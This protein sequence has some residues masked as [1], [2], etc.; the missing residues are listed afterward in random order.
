MSSRPSVSLSWK[1]ESR[2]LTRSPT[3]RLGRASGWMPWKDKC[4]GLLVHWSPSWGV[5]A[6][7]TG[8]DSCRTR[9]GSGIDAHLPSWQAPLD[10]PPPPLPSTLTSRWKRMM[11][12]RAS[13]QWRRLGR[14]RC[15]RGGRY[16]KMDELGA[17]C[18]GCKARKY[19]CDH[20]NKTHAKTMT[21]RRLVSD[22][23]SEEEE[24]MK[25]RSHLP[26]QTCLVV[27]VAR[28]QPT[29]PA[30]PFAMDRP[31]APDLAALRRSKSAYH[32]SLFCRLGGVFFF[33]MHTIVGVTPIKESPLFHKSLTM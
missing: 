19:G 23:G 2:P 30:S 17:A 9:G 31:P 24:E 27:G 16:C 6:L 21:V 26:L 1:Q 20:T 25:V 11:P 5:S 15:E 33:F 4:T 18:A 10:P 14:T 7:T 29:H 13:N 8:S 22:S 28:R 12:G 32:Y 3:K